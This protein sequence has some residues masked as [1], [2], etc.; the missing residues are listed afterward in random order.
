MIKISAA[1]WDFSISPGVG[2]DRGSFEHIHN[3]AI[4]CLRYPRP[5]FFARQESR[6]HARLYRTEYV[7]IDID[8]E[9][10][11]NLAKHPAGHI[12]AL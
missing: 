3:R 2:R 4:P 1:R 5:G 11:A 7:R 10:F 9:Q 8:P 12:G 6:D